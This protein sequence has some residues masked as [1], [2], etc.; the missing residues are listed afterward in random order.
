MLSLLFSGRWNK[1]FSIISVSSIL[2]ED[3]ILDL[4][5]GV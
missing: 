5:S 4:S 3:L 1:L 2:I